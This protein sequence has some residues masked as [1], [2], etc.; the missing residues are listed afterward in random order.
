MPVRL[1]ARRV[2]GALLACGLPALWYALYSAGLVDSAQAWLLPAIALP[3]L[4][5]LRRLHVP[6]GVL[7]AVAIVSL[8]FA[9]DALWA[10]R[11]DGPLDDHVVVEGDVAFLAEPITRATPAQLRAALAAYPQIRRVQFGSD[12]GNA[13]AGV[14]LARLIRARGLDT[15]TA[16]DFFCQSACTYAFYGGMRRVAAAGCPLRF[17]AEGG[18]IP[19]VAAVMTRVHHA[20]LGLP[21]ALARDIRV[22]GQQLLPLDSRL[23]RDRDGYVTKI[24]PDRPSMPCS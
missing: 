16:P 12:G 23:L 1:R 8:W 2:G 15:E 10:T 20:V 18:A 24:D 19:L 3:L 13:M 11:F 9:F 6:S 17:H 7:V 22:T 21:S 14:Q 5:G 4:T